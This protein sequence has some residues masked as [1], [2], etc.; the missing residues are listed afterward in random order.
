MNRVRGVFRVKRMNLPRTL[1]R[2]VVITLVALCAI[3]ALPTLP[4]SAAAAGAEPCSPAWLSGTGRAGSL[5]AP[6]FGAPPA[7]PSAATQAQE[8]GAAG[9]TAGSVARPNEPNGS[10]LPSDELYYAGQLNSLRVIR[11]LDAWETTFGGDDVTVAVIAD[12]VDVMHPDLNQR[13]W[14]NS[15]EVANGRDDDGNGYVDDVHG[16]DFGD[17]DGDLSPI[18]MRGTLLAGIVGAE[19]NN[20]IGVA[21]VNWHARVMPLKVYK[22]YPIAGGGQGIGAYPEDFTRSVCYAANNGARIILFSYFNFIGIQSACAW[23]S[24]MPMTTAS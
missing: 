22:A 16:W 15:A 20:G 24:T 3:G 18:G 6:M 14:R 10:S 23:P 19:T 13:I 11:A 5:A 8:S 7:L 1:Q 9:V 21:A 2:F 17:G 12:G 4:S